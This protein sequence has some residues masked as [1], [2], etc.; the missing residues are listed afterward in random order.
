MF[1]STFDSHNSYQDIPTTS[2]PVDLRTLWGVASGN[3]MPGLFNL[4]SSFLPLCSHT[5]VNFCDVQSFV[6]LFASIVGTVTYPKFLTIG[7]N[8]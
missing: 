6:K 7:F 3:Q 2:C 1:K 8:M 4:E 5:P